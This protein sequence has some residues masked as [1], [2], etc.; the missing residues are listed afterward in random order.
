MPIENRN[1]TVGTNLVTKYKKE[2]YYAEVVEG[3]EGKVRYRLKD[4]G[5]VRWR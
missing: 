4:G 1:L 3:Q 2:S 5:P